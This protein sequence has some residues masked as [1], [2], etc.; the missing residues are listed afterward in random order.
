MGSIQLL[1][2]QL[3]SQLGVDPTSADAVLVDRLRLTLRSTRLPAAW[4][5]LAVSK[6]AVRQE[7]LDGI[8]YARSSEGRTAVELRRIK[9][10]DN[11][12]VTALPPLILS[13][14][15]HSPLLSPSARTPHRC[16]A[17]MIGRRPKGGYA[18]IQAWVYSQSPAQGPSP[19][20]SP[21]E[22]VPRET[23]FDRSE[24][25]PR[26]GTLRSRLGYIPSHRPRGLALAT[27]P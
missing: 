7:V 15:S 23:Y 12:C 19:S 14:P 8:E 6:E 25:D 17:L 1:A 24:G 3:R 21:L 26:G 5:S 10:L 27:L 13:S 9:L 18:Q 11:G 16:G 22:V 20:H 4:R 2:A